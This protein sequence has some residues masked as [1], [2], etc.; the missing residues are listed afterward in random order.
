MAANSIEDYRFIKEMRQRIDDVLTNVIPKGKERVF[1][2]DEWAQIRDAF[3]DVGGLCQEAESEQ[4][5]RIR[6]MFKFARDYGYDGY[7]LEPYYHANWARNHWEFMAH[8]AGDPDI[9]G[10]YPQDISK[11]AFNH[12]IDYRIARGEVWSKTDTE[13]MNRQIIARIKRAIENGNRSDTLTPGDLL[14]AYVYEPLYTYENRDFGSLPT[15]VLGDCSIDDLKPS[16][17]V[18]DLLGRSYRIYADE[19][20]QQWAAW[21]ESFEPQMKQMYQ[22]GEKEAHAPSPRAVISAATKVASSAG[23]VDTETRQHRL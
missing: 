22:S 17:E 14:N 2:P 18:Y 11:C 16:K 13:L 23:T 8:F 12:M 10:I 4:D 9:E 6:D 7:Y 5:T 19:R 1:T 3:Y 20:D 21:Y 15:S